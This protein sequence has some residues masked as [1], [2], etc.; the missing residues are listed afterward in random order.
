MYYYRGSCLCIQYSKQS[1]NSIYSIQSRFGKL[2]QSLHSIDWDNSICKHSYTS[3]GYLHMNSIMYSFLHNKMNSMNGM[4]HTLKLSHLGS[5][6]QHIQFRPH[7]YNS[8]DNELAPQFHLLCSKFHCNLCNQ[9]QLLSKFY[10][11]YSVH[12]YWQSNWHNSHQG[13]FLCTLSSLDHNS[14]FYCKLY[15]HSRQIQYIWHSR[16]GMWYINLWSY[17]HIPL[18]D[19]QLHIRCCLILCNSHYLNHIQ[20]NQQ[21]L[22]RPSI[23]PFPLHRLHTSLYYYL[24][25]FLSHSLNKGRCNH[26]HSG[27][28]GWKFHYILYIR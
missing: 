16:K 15:S 7:N 25:M 3:K 22:H 11:Q 24:Q 10:K 6:Q 12:T 2:C 5:C 1:Y 14:R 18:K 26:V 13:M 19:T 28:T 27:K 21:N 20:Y 9:W 17:L 4:I 8:K 23:L